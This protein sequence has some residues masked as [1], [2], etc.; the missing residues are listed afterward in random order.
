MSVTT[1]TPTE[2]ESSRHTEGVRPSRAWYFLLLPAIGL[3][4][5]VYGA[6]RGQVF[7][8]FVGLAWLFLAI[9]QFVMTRRR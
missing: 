9:T 4:A 5:A 2:R 7:W 6:V 8:I 3:G 1:Q